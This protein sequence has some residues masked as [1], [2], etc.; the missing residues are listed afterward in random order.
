MNSRELSSSAAQNIDSECHLPSEIM[1]P[2]QLAAPQPGF[3][4]CPQAISNIVTAIA[5]SRINHHILDSQER[6]A[7]SKIKADR[8]KANERERQETKR[9][10]IQVFC[11][12]KK[13]QDDHAHELE[14]WK[15][16]RED[17]EQGF[18]RLEKACDKCSTDELKNLVLQAMI[19][20]ATSGLDDSR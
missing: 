14:L 13:K 20:I 10:E 7:R 18:E 16:R 2:G 1:S 6:V 17:K 8:D 5:Q 4:S 12:I 15:Q 9:F 3:A 11:D 19:K